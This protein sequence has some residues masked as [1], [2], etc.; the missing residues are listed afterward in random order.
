MPLNQK[1]S[2]TGLLRMYKKNDLGQQQARLALSSEQTDG[3]TEAAKL[4]ILENRPIQKPS[5]SRFDKPAV[6]QEGETGNEKTT[7]RKRRS[8]WAQQDEEKVVV[9]GMSTNVPSK[10]NP[11]QQKLYVLQLQ[12][13]DC[14]RRLRTANYGIPEDPRD[15][16]PSPEPIYDQAGKRLNTREYRWKRKVQNHRH[17]CITKMIQLH[18]EYRAPSD[19]K[20]PEAKLQERIE[21][22]AE[23]FPQLNFIGLLIGPRGLTLRKLERESGAR[24]MLRGKGSVKENKLLSGRTYAAMEEPLHALVSAPDDNSLKKAVAMVTTIVKTAVENPTGEQD[25][26]K[27][28]VM[29]L[30]KLNGTLRDG[31]FGSGMAWLKTE[32]EGSTVVNQTVCTVCGGRGHLANDCKMARPGTTHNLKRNAKIQV[33]TKQHLDSEYMA[34]MSEL[35][36]TTSAPVQLAVPQ[37][38]AGGTH[39]HLA[40][41]SIQAAQAGKQEAIEYSKPNA[42]GAPLNDYGY[43]GQLMIEDGGRAVVKAKKEDM[44]DPNAL[45]DGIWNNKEMGMTQD[46]TVGVHEIVKDYQDSDRAIVQG[47]QNFG[48]KRRKTYGQS[49]PDGQNG[50]NVAPLAIEGGVDPNKHR[51]TAQIHSRDYATT[52]VQDLEQQTKNLVRKQ[53]NMAYA[54]MNREVDAAA[55]TAIGAGKY[56]SKEALGAG[57]YGGQGYVDYDERRDK[58]SKNYDPKFAR[59]SHNSHWNHGG[60]GNYNYNQQGGA[61]YNNNQN[62]KRT[63]YTGNRDYSQTN[64][65]AP[66]GPQGPPNPHSRDVGPANRMIKQGLGYNQNRNPKNSQ[67]TN[68]DANKAMEATR[69]Y[70]GDS[71]S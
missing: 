19:Y 46:Y 61:I 54:T 55:Y 70:M 5:K 23:Q 33:E 53:D 8:R 2:Q 21:I 25:L 58:N 3:K 34:L 45:G 27:L 48:A 67:R 31:A 68:I 47:D 41:Q 57:G 35:G 42:P 63:G 11:L 43:G 17:A 69:K 49:N 39:S 4:K 26:R 6:K 40:T 7:K 22:P 30:A 24:I 28:Q 62:Y 37:N 60:T 14:T 44:I 1:D 56:S 13:E 66:I 20:A 50:P 71:Y 38:Y 52:A 12:I 51:N 16:S 32:G 29:E 15:R 10:L 65:M 36:Q 9:P 64:M 59:N 18:P